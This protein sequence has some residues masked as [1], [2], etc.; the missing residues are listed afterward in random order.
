MNTISQAIALTVLAAS[1][2]AINGCAVLRNQE[3]V[4]A[5]V[6]DSSITT[7]VKARFIEDPSVDAVAIGVETLKGTVQLTGF[8]KSN[9]ERTRAESIARG[10]SGVTAVQNRISVRP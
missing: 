9:D 4:G 10:V 8:A 1:L 3:S 6:D 2:T 7:R 5:Y